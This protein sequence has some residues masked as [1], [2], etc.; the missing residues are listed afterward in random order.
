M[1]RPSPERF[2]LALK[3]RGVKASAADLN[4]LVIKSIGTTQIFAPPPKPKGRVYAVDKD[5]RWMAD[6][7][8]N[9]TTPST[10]QGVT[11]RAV[12]LVQDVFTRYAFAEPM[13][14]QSG[15]TKA[16]EW[17]FKRVERE[18]HKPPTV[19]MTGE[20]GFFKAPSFAAV[21]R[22]NRVTHVFKESQN[23]IGTVD[24]LISTV[25]RHLAQESAESGKA[26]WAANL[27][28]VVKGYNDSPP[29]E[30]VRLVARGRAEAT[31]D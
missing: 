17:I 21:F 12:L 14:S 26:N 4:N 24:R 3:K 16:M 13:E 30:A 25:R 20:D 23:D 8:V 9:S 19:L 10:H 31:R 18:G 22:S 11:Y 15:A 29:T 6:I 28:K 5:Q 27:Q 7:I 2:S 1:N